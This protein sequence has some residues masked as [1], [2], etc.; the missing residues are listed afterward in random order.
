MIVWTDDK[1]NWPL[2]NQALMHQADTY[3]G[4]KTQSKVVAQLTLL[5]AITVLARPHGG[6]RLCAGLIPRALMHQADTYAGLE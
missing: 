2:R 3:A 1:I 6:S 5:V 4:F